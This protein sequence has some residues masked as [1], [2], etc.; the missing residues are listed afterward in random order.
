VIFKDAFIAG[1]FDVYIQLTDFQ[2]GKKTAPKTRE[3]LLT[4][5][6]A[7]LFDL[8]SFKLYYSVDD[9]INKTSNWSYMGRKDSLHV[10][11]KQYFHIY[12][13]QGTN[14]LTWHYEGMKIGYDSC[15]FEFSQIVEG[16]IIAEKIY[17]T[18]QQCSQLVLNKEIMLP[19][20]GKGVTGLSLNYWL[21]VLLNFGIVDFDSKTDFIGLQWHSWRSA[22]GNMT[23]T[24]LIKNSPKNKIVKVVDNVSG[25]TNE[26]R[27]EIDSV[28]NNLRKVS[29]YDGSSVNPPGVTPEF[30]RAKI[31]FLTFNEMMTRYETIPSAKRMMSG[32]VTTTRVLE[33]LKSLDLTYSNLMSVVQNKTLNELGASG[34]MQYNYGGDMRPAT[35]EALTTGYDFQVK[36][37]NNEITLANN[38]VRYLCTYEEKIPESVVEEYDV[39]F[40][41]EELGLVVG[42]SF[43]RQ[44]YVNNMAFM[45]IPSID[46]SEY[47]AV[48]NTV[49]TVNLENK[50]ITYQFQQGGL[51][52]EP[53]EDMMSFKGYMFQYLYFDVESYLSTKDPLFNLK[54]KYLFITD[55]NET[56]LLEITFRKLLSQ[57]WVYEISGEGIQKEIPGYY[58]NAL[59]NPDDIKVG[60]KIEVNE[61]FME[62]FEEQYQEM[63]LQGVDFFT[64]KDIQY[65]SYMGMPSIEVEYLSGKNYITLPRQEEL[66]LK[67]LEQ[68]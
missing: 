21:S 36:I 26:I 32:L 8:G 18:A 57:D 38:F 59:Y 10:I 66:F 52:V 49:K 35:G 48:A 55:R 67:N 33:M 68:L 45:T 37:G 60:D 29:F 1:E 47:L 20:L 39:Q 58:L 30:I 28:L 14:E 6:E 11:L 34:V 5:H 3:L 23:I 15:L 19:T 46:P 62:Y 12:I 9:E 40:D 53:Q 44:S 63:K 17:L 65:R 41:L 43:A 7:A 13:R 2:K 4:N 54:Q 42:R 31:R 56:K 50:T 16:K 51:N 24:E 27:L 22:S 64:I 25:G 61:A